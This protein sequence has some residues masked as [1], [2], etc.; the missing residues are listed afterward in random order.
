MADTPATHGVLFNTDLLDIVL[1]HSARTDIASLRL[2]C[3]A[4]ETAASPHLFRRLVLSS[5]K[6]HLRRLKRIA[7]D[8]KFAKGVRE[9]V[10]ETAHYG[11]NV[12]EDN[13]LSDDQEF[14]RLLYLS[15]YDED[16]ELWSAERQKKCFARLRSLRSHDMSVWSAEFLKW[17]R[18]NFSKL[19][20]LNSLVFTVWNAGENG[21]RKFFDPYV[22]YQ[23]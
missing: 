18:G 20:G 19:K 7:D 2:C 9:V 15:G 12:P 21:E 11:T 13:V 10:W 14:T 22:I 3:T 23:R 1:L 17:L 4:L 16:H 8:E 5:R 6:R